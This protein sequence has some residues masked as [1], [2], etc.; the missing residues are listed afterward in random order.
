[1]ALFPDSV[2]EAFEN[3]ALENPEECTANPYIVPAIR[4]EGTLYALASVVGGRTYRWL[5]GIGGVAGVVVALFPDRYLEFGA[6]IAYE[7]PEAVDWND[8]FVTAVRVLGV[9][10]VLLALNA[11]RSGGNGTD[12]VSAT[13]RDEPAEGDA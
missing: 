2:L 1:M 13:Q 12:E 5:L 3:V 7:N 8:D 11:A 6:E 4:A 9:V 10:L